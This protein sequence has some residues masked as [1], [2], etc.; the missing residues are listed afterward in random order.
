VQGEIDVVG[1]NLKNEEIFICEVAIHLITG[2]QYVRDNRPN[3]INKLTEKFSKNIDYTNKYFP[4]HIKHVMLWSPIVKGGAEYARNNQMRDVRKVCENIKT[5]YKVELE[6]IANE[7]F[8]A[9]IEELREH[10]RKETKESKSPV[11]RLLQIEERLKI[12]KTQ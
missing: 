1:I 3:N 10:A 2:L 12:L 11:V 5:K 4:K 8:L 6:V 7:K 9:C